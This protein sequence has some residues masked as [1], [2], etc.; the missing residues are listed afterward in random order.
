ML[1]Y[2]G[3]N[4]SLKLRNL[5]RQKMKDNLRQVTLKLDDIFSLY[6]FPNQKLAF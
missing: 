4:L 5:R 1:R 6:C 3:D 2:P